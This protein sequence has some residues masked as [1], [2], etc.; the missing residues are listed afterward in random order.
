MAAFVQFG[1][2][3]SQITWHLTHTRDFPLSALLFYSFDTLDISLQLLSLLM[4]GFLQYHISSNTDSGNKTKRIE[5]EHIKIRSCMFAL[6]VLFI[7]LVFLDLTY[8]RWI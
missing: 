1:E 7:A 2:N 5:N 3:D 8:R 6:A 4:A